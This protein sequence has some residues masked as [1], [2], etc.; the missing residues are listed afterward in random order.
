MNQ[1][2]RDGVSFHAGVV[3]LASVHV[4]MTTAVRM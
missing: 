4:E 1:R 2:G 3:A